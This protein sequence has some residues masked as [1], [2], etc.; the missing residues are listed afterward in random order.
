VAHELW[1]THQW[2]QSSEE[3]A[4]QALFDAPEFIDPRDMAELNRCHPQAKTKYLNLYYEGQIPK[5]IKR[6]HSL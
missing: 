5:S 2:A 1:A 6:L 3:Q 4:I